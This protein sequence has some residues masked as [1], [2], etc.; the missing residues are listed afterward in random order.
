MYRHSEL[1]LL[2]GEILEK[3][4]TIPFYN[5]ASNKYQHKGSP[6]LGEPWIYVYV[7]IPLYNRDLLLEREAR[8]V[9]T[10]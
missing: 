6:F 3:V 10:A 4:H 9:R 7:S 1:G 5:I 2:P 8:I